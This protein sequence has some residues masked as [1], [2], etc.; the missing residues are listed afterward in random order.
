MNYITIGLPKQS[1]YG[2]VVLETF[3]LYNGGLYEANGLSVYFSHIVGLDPNKYGI[4]ES[5]VLQAGDCEG[6][7]GNFCVDAEG[8]LVSKT[9]LSIIVSWIG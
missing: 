2:D 8:Y 6:G 7:C 9:P 4:T 5:S 1:E 3:T